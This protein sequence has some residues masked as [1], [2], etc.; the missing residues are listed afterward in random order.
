MELAGSVWKPLAAHALTS[1]QRLGA[2][3][4]STV[5]RLFTYS[6]TARSAKRCS[7]AR[8]EAVVT[9]VLIA[10]RSG[11]AAGTTIVPITSLLICVDS[12][13]A[14]SRRRL[15]DIRR[16]TLASTSRGPA[17]EVAS[18]ASG[19][20]ARA[21]SWPA[22]RSAWPRRPSSRAPAWRPTAATPSSDKQG[23][24]HAFRHCSEPTTC[25]PRRRHEE[26]GKDA[27]AA[28]I[29]SLAR[30]FPDIVEASMHA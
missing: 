9:K 27:H 10:D 18:D 5:F 4:L 13:P 26:V 2:G 25:A 14:V 15:P 17:S 12:A 30:G 8:P 22:R 1:A 24:R 7:S 16:F 28:R 3:R 21:R 29:P 23:E 20:R 6:C 11:C 19:R